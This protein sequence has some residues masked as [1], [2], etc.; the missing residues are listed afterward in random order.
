MK[1][2]LSTQNPHLI[3][4]AGLRDNRI[5]K[6][7]SFFSVEGAR[8]INRALATGWILKELFYSQELLS[9]EGE[10]VTR[11]ALCPLIRVIPKAFA[12]LVVRE[13]G[14]GVYAV[15][16]K[17]TKTLADLKPGACPFYV[18]VHGIEK[19]GNLGAI[20]RSAD[21]AGAHGLIL[22]DEKV[23]LYHPQVIRGSLGT[24]F[25]LPWVSCGVEEFLGFAKKLTLFGAS[26]K[27]PSMVYHRADYTGPLGLL[28]GSEDQG[29]PKALLDQVKGVRIPMGGIADSLNVSVA[30]GILLYE[31]GRQ[32]THGSQPHD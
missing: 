2:I 6:K 8:E 20:I 10:E 27:E 3:D 12:K 4:A 14:D 9:K 13:S 29:L 26:L 31:V 16:H 25:S 15:F 23:D 17:K 21:G 5:R 32:R 1:E 24:V 7:S 30:A 11:Q 28:F 18:V 22:L 19:P